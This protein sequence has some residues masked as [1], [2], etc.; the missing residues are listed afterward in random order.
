MLRLLI[1]FFALIICLS[2]CRSHNQNVVSEKNI[3]R[4]TSDHDNYNVRIKV[5]NDWIEKLRRFDYS[6]NTKGLLHEFESF[7]KPETIINPGGHHVDEDYG[8][9]LN[10]MFV[11][12]DGEPGEELICLIGWDVGSPYLGVLNNLKGNGIYCISRIFGCLTKEQNC[13]LPIIFQRIRFFI[14]G[15]CMAG[16]RVLMQMV[17]LFTSC[18]ITKFTA[19][20]SW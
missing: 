19:A 9:V 3:Y 2:S 18:S 20:W 13:L 17:I 12:L 6:R 16:V 5:S 1:A 4:D 11:N 14:A 7:I 15:I 10:P 8:R